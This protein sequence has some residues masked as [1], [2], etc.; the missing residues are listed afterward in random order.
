MLEYSP[1][2]PNLAELDHAARMAPDFL[3]TPIAVTPAET[4]QQFML[5][6]LVC[7][8]LFSLERCC[9]EIRAWLQVAW[10]P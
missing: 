2:V 4:H 6:P 10:S 1:H 9:G 8:A 7:C 3:T 5:A